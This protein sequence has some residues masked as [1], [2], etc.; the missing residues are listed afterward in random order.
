MKCLC[1]HEVFG[2]IMTSPLTN[3]HQV[4]GAVSVISNNQGKLFSQEDRMLLEILASEA[5]I[6]VAYSQITNEIESSRHNLENV[7]D[8]IDSPIVTVNELREI[9]YANR[10]EFNMPTG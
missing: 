5:S 6:G 9:Q 3:Q 1:G 10:V 4:I 7:L 8:A 2:S